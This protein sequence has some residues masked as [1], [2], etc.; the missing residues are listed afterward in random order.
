MTA[1]S[2]MHAVPART[3]ILT[4]DCDWA[5]DFVLDHVREMLDGKHAHATLFVTHPSSAL[6]AWKASSRFELGWHPNFLPGSTQGR[7]PAAVAA[8][9]ETIAPGARSMRTHDL[10][11]STS[12]LRDF[13]SKAPR[14]RYDT[15][16][17]LPGQASLA[18]FDLLFGA[19]T[20]LRRYPFVWE[21]DLHL[22]AGG[23]G[24][25][26]LADLPAQGLCIVNFHPIHIY[27][28]TADFSDYAKVR[29][30]GPMQALTAAQME[31]FRN[32]AAGIGTVFANALETV[33]F[34]K[35]LAEFAE[36]EAQAGNPTDGADALDRIDPRR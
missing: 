27:L 32:P 15:S 29:A 10:F 26:R 31:P 9:L 30:L 12:L 23:T 34:S 6:A 17:Y 11:Q 8:Y 20:K 24:D 5:P 1:A 21:D 7:D 13:L 22:L 19:D 16:L 35:H 14:I 3:F 28:N 36:W 4:L 2:L 25:F 33:D 18:G